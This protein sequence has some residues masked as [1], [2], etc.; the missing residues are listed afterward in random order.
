MNAISGDREQPKIT[1]RKERQVSRSDARCIEPMARC[2]VFRTS[3]FDKRSLVRSVHRQAVKSVP[4]CYSC[5][6][7]PAGDEDFAAESDVVRVKRRHAAPEGCAA[8]DLRLIQL[9]DAWLNL[10]PALT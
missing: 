8:I 10:P 5:A 2:L 7:V 6:G 9:E 3:L 4:Q 1:V